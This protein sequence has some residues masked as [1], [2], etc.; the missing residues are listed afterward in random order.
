LWRNQRLRRLATGW[1]LP[2]LLSLTVLIGYHS[3]VRADPTPST[4]ELQAYL[5]HNQLNVY[6]EVA[7]DYPQIF[8]LYN[9]RPI[10]LT[11]DNYTHIHPAADGQYIAW[12]AIINGQT[13]VFLYDVLSDSLLQ[14]SSASPNEGIYM[15]ANQ[16]VWQGWDGA[17]WQIFYYDGSQVQQITDNQNSSFHPIIDSHQIVY[18]EQLGNDS[19]RAQAYDLVTHQVSVVREGDTV[20]TAYPSFDSDGRVSTS[21]IPH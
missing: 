21:Y 8:Y 17:H 2:I 4:T 10:Q 1:V 19:W 16:V 9:R 7:G 11:S 3:Q 5:E 13:Q 12:L 18:S 6:E 14:L 15:H 20:S